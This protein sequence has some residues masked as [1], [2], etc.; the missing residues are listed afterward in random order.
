MFEI[1]EVAPTKNKSAFWAKD[2]KVAP[3][4]LNECEKPKPVNMGV[5][6]K[7]L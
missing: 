1:K 2:I 6:K 4:S 3:R 7:G 5:I